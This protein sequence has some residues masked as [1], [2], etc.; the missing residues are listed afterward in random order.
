MASGTQDWWG[1][2]RIDIISQTIA[3]LIER[4]KYGGADEVFSSGVLA[5]GGQVALWTIGGT[6]VI[7]GGYIRVFG[8]AAAQ[9]CYIEIDIDTGNMRSETL[10]NM[11]RYGLDTETCSVGY[12][13]GYDTATNLYAIGIHPWLTFESAVQVRLYNGGTAS[14]SYNARMQYALL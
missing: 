3:H 13:L 4:P 2:R 5:A 9:D 14:V 7:Y 10:Q 6:G 11:N 8:S 1:R 12:L